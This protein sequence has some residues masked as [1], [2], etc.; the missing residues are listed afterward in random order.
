[1]NAPRTI[2]TAAVAAAALAFALIASGAAAGQFSAWGPPVSAE[3]WIAGTSTELNTASADGCPILSPD[4]LD[5]YMASSR[6]GGLGANATN[7]IWVAHRSST[8]APFGA[9]V[10]LGAPVNSAAN[11]FCPTPTLGGGLFFVSD[12][13]VA[14]ACGGPDIYF[15][16]FR[17]GAW[18]EPE[19]LGC[20]VNSAAGE[21]GPSLVLAGFKPAL[22][23][24]SARAGGVSE[25]AAGVTSGDSDIYMSPLTKGGFGAATLVPGLNT[26]AN[27]SRPNV[28][29]DG[30]EIVFDSDRDSATVG[31]ADIY[32]ASRT[33]LGKP[34]SA[35]VSLGPTVNTT[36]NESR[37]SLSWDG[38]TMVFGSNRPGSEAGSGDIYVTTRERIH[39]GKR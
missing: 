32:T 31:V 39:R 14:G 18:T 2:R 10:N 1:M 35:P 26:A 23:F 37:A 9:P 11:D 21:A 34:W 24:S 6:P 27:D 12:R 4:G 15:T 20:Q 22:Y 13:V 30:L 3:L 8:T 29:H 36:S 5:L 38:R 33:G 17:H 19:N 28:R 25:E 7:D 16:R